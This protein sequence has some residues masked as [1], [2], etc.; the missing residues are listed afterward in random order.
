MAAKQAGL[1]NT[2]TR[3]STDVGNEPEQSKKSEGGPESA[4]AVGTI[5]PKRPQSS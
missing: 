1:S 3:H 5:D 4:K 2:P